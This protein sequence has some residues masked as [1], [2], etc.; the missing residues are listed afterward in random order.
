MNE[1]PLSHN[2]NRILIIGALLGALSGVIAAY[3]L[4]Q[5]AEKEGSDI[6]ISTV[7]GVKLGAMIFG[8]LRQI[9][10]LVG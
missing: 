5:R 6:R 3:M 8:T 4:V 10:Q 9:A 7:D 1:N 2:T